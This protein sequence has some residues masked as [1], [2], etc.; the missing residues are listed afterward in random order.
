MITLL[1]LA[2]APETDPRPRPGG[3]TDTTDD[4]TPPAPAYEPCEWIDQEVIRT[5]EAC[6]SYVV[7]EDLG[8]VRMVVEAGTLVEVAPGVS[9]WSYGDLDI[10]GTPAEPVV[11]R[12]LDPHAG[13]S[14][15]MVDTGT[16]PSDTLLSIAGLEL[17]DAGRNGFSAALSTGGDYYP[18]GSGGSGYGNPQG[19]TLVLENVSIHGSESAGIA[20]G[21]A[22]VALTPVGF[23]N[24]AG[25][26]VEETSLSG[27]LGTDLAMDLG[28]NA[29]P[30][31]ET[32]HLSALTVRQSVPLR[33]LRGGG[34]LAIGDEYTPYE[35][36]AMVIEPNDLRFA[37]GAWLYA[38]GGILTIDGC[39]L[40]ADDPANPWLGIVGEVRLDLE[41]GL[42]VTNSSLS[43]AA[44]QGI[45]WAVRS[46]PEISGT[47]ISGIVAE[48]GDD[49][50]VVTC[51]DLLAPELGN[52]F[53]CT[54]PI[55]CEAP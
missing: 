20:G 27:S 48:D 36:R 30:V 40:S 18:G 4:P 16:P 49:V 29:D 22:L 32:T 14:S 46:A 25:P 37:G 42:A 39:T 28:G 45:D 3:G 15:L 53:A 55:R 54:T 24:I 7:N 38:L 8:L 23:E 44:G 5:T 19:Y 34:A 10:R 11:F 21:H 2:C 12:A 6:P 47:T 13:W 33:V 50:C 41:P 52:T 9:I 35:R 31:I 43:G 51:A 1:V 26:L 17:R